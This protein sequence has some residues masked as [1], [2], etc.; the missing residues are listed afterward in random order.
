MLAGRLQKIG[1]RARGVKRTTGKNVAASYVDGF[2]WALRALAAAV[3]S[4][5]ALSSHQ[6]QTCAPHNRMSALL[7]IAPAKADSCTKP[8]LLCPRKRTCAVQEAMSALGQ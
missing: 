3:F 8:C 2:S 6:K 4:A 7:S 1:V 5:R